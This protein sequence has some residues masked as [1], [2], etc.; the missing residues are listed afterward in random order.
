[1]AGYVDRVREEDSGVVCGGSW[2]GSR[3]VVFGDGVWV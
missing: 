3:R 1:V 2:R